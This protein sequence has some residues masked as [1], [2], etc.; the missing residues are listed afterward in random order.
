MPYPMAGGSVCMPACAYT[1]PH[2]HVQEGFPEGKHRI[3]VTLFILTVWASTLFGKNKSPLTPGPQ[4]SE[5]ALSAGPLAKDL[6]THLHK[7]TAHV[8]TFSISPWPLP[9]LN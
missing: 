6:W 5:A 1:P 4:C 7:G 2:T 9:P 8:F 3:A